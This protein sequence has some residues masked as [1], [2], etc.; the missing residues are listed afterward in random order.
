MHQRTE[1]D[2]HPALTTTAD[3]PA[4]PEPRAGHQAGQEPGRDAGQVAA[5]VAATYERALGSTGDGPALWGY[6]ALAW[7]SGHLAAMHRAV[8]PA[9]RRR[10]GEN[11]QLL[12]RCRAEAR[13]TAWAL[14]VLQSHLAGDGGTGA[15][16]PGIADTWLQQCLDEYRSAEHALIAWMHKRLTAQEHEHLAAAYRA[17]LTHAPTRPHP[18]GPHTGWP[19]HAAFRFHALWDGLLDAVDSRPGVRRTER[20]TPVRAWPPPPQLPRRPGGVLPA[21][22][23]AGDVLPG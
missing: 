14:R 3:H 12:Q 21:D 16:E 17:A 13:E 1:G 10:L 2:E 15:R 11:Q 23:A 19:G 5:L 7:L 6:R 20:S 8:Y 4:V 9:A 22:N 18:R